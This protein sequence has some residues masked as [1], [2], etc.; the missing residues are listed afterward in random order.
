MNIEKNWK[1]DI[2][3]F[4][5]S[6]TVSLFGSSLVQ[7]AIM[8]YITLQTKSGLMMTISIICGF[9]PVFFLSPFAGVWAD[10][11]NRKIL[12]ML[13]DSLIA[14]CTLVM[15]ILFFSGYREIWLLFAASSIRAFGTGI[16]TPAVNAFIP[17]MVPEDKLTKVMATNGSIQSMVTL[18]SPMASGALLTVTSIETIFLVDVFTA[19]IA[20]VIL[21]FLHVKPHKRALERQETSY[22]K[23]MK[24]GIIYIK[25]HG[26]LKV[27]FMFMAVYY[28]LVSPSAFLT[29]LQVTRT[30]G[31][32][33][34]RLTAIEVVFSVGMMAGGLIMASWGGYKNKIYTMTLSGLV[35]GLCSIALGLV[36][37]FWVYILFMGLFGTAM[38]IFNTPAM[39]L[40]Q[41]KVDGNFLGRVFSVMSMISSIMMPA[42]MLVFGPAADKV[43]IEYLLIGTGIL[44]MMLTVLFMKNNSMLEAG[45]TVTVQNGEYD[46]ENNK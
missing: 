36:P 13:S 4:L 45:K 16:Q 20:V 43:K 11:Y 1:N 35:M 34:W 26:F 17:Q 6:Q 30:F 46:E 32:D 44:I 14:V 28:I 19:L 41:E 40:L 22:I 24:D 27:F 38:P 9:L 37:D 3:L 21:F 12:I 15:A 10:R 23:D 42:A 5:A 25:E 8:W 2:V 39:V 29:P 33:V 18:L 7:Y 31:D